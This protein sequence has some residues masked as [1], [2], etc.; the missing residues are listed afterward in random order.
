MARPLTGVGYYTLSL[1][2]A[3]VSE[4]TDL[5]VRVFASSARPTRDLFETLQKS[6]SRIRTLPWPTR[7]KNR[8]WTGL[9]WPPIEW[10]T[11]AVDIA[12]G[13]FHLLPPSRRAKRVVTIFDLSNLRYPEMHRA[14]SFGIHAPLLR[15]AAAKADCILAISQSCKKDIVE[16]LGVAEERVSVVYGGVD[17][18]EFGGRLDA[19]LLAS[20]RAR[21]GIKGGYFIHLGT[22]EPRKNLP[23]LLEAYARVRSRMRDCPQLVLAGQAGWLFDDVFAAV[24]RLGLAGSVIHTGYLARNEAVVL[25]RGAYACVY[26]SLYEGFGLPVLEAMAARV[27]VMTSNVSS[28]PEVAGNT[29]TLVDPNRVEEIEAGL[30]ELLDHRDA[31]IARVEAAYARAQGFSWR[32]SA[33]TLAAVYKELHG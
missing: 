20:L 4:F 14:E 12:H 31:A 22:L 27:P 32:S 19:G 8:M 29:G 5:D 2:N 30:M 28:M 1:F 16:L 21:F 17:V 15:H 18:D 13:A 9:E 33:N 3:L 7:L 26:P 25:L 10:F 6:V 23:R 24:E 11:G